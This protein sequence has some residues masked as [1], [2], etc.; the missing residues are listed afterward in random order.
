MTRIFVLALP[1]F[2][3]VLAANSQS[4]E[5]EAW[6]SGAANQILEIYDGQSLLVIGELHGNSETPMLVASLVRNL[7]DDGPVTVALEIP[8]QEQ[9]RIDRFLKSDGSPLAISK[10]LAGQSWQ[11]PAKES[12]GRRSKAMLEPLDTIRELHLK[13]AEVDIATLDD[14]DFYAEGS[15]RRKGM[16]DRIAGLGQALKQGPVLIL[17]G[18]F[19]ARLTPFSGTLLSDGKPIEP[20]RP[21][22]GFVQGVPLTSLNVAACR[23]S[24]WSCRDG[25]CGPI[26]LSR[27]PCEHEASAELVKLDPD[28]DGYHYTMTLPE[29][30]SSSPAR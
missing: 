19:H 25:K 13:G 28:R 23:G 3:L 15:N 16:A 20:P 6:L 11:V 17:M 27:A 10:L 14:L 8:R 9:Q 24:S 5:S 2:L 26:E 1:I 29:V 30:T 7:A 4:A 22:A 21:T 12:D 18:N